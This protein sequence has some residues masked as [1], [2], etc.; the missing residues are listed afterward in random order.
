MLI[1]LASTVFFLFKKN[2]KLSKDGKS[3]EPEVIEEGPNLSVKQSIW[4]FASGLMVLLISANYLVDAA[5][6]LASLWGISELIIG[7]TVIAIGT[8]LPELA[9]TIGGVLKK[10]NDL[11]IG[12][13]VGSNI[14]NLLSVLPMASMVTPADIPHV[15][16]WRDYAVMGVMTLL[17][18]LFAYGFSPK[19]MID[20]FE[21]FMLL[22][23]YIAYSCLLVFQ[24]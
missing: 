13:L 14:L 1:L 7:L 18:A 19:P 10:Q 24:V 17:L 12:T 22:M 6:E 2:Q 4:Q 11:V 9:T 15:A 3:P 21:G 16:L 8:S 23:A 20:R 5:E